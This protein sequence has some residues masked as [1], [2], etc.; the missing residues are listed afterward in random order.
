MSNSHGGS[1]LDVFDTIASRPRSSA[2]LVSPPPPHGQ[3][4]RTSERGTGTVAPPLPQPGPASIAAAALMRRASRPSAPPPP[5]SLPAVPAPS[6]PEALTL[7]ASSGKAAPRMPPSASVPSTPPMVHV[8]P[9]PVATVAG[10]DPLD[11]VDPEPLEEDL[12]EAEPFEA[13]PAETAQPRT[14]LAPPGPQDAGPGL[15]ALLEAGDP[16]A[17]S[18]IPPPEPPITGPLP[19]PLPP[20]TKP[21]SIPPVSATTPAPAH[22]TPASSP[23]PVIPSLAPTTV[24]DSESTLRLTAK[25]KKSRTGLVAAAAVFVAMAGIGAAAL[26][27]TPRQGT[28]RV[29]VSGTQGQEVGPVEIYVD[30]N[31]VCSSSPCIVGALDPGIHD[32]YAQAPGYARTAT[33][34][35]PISRGKEVPVEIE[36]ARAEPASPPPEIPVVHKTDT[37]KARATF[38]LAAHNVAMR[39]VSQEGD[40]RELDESMFQDNRLSIDVDTTRQWKLQ[41]CAP[42][43]DLLELPLV[44][45]QGDQEKSFRIE[46]TKN[47]WRTKARLESWCK[48]LPATKTPAAAAPASPVA[49]AASGSGTINV[50]SV[51]AGAAVLLDG[52]PVGRTPLSGVKVSAGTHALVFVHPEKGRKAASV[53]VD[54][55]QS[56]GVGVRF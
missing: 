1:D 15:A 55:G 7:L 13:E 27:I 40:A 33:K 6:R 12:A 37:T 47:P 49:K 41:A 20:P 38:E 42:G 21:A 51:P 24:T 46:L 52:K 43:H 17:S 44:F 36:L 31:K 39:L 22:W 10:A 14:D 30:D 2:P 54:A 11:W 53:T 56:R 25:K 4:S 50:N 28:M 26:L 19:A 34:G 29:Y 9:P 23:R 18:R 45:G 16:T 5:P 48:A 8:A 3:P 35:V 32:V